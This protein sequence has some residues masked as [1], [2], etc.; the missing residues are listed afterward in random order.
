MISGT[1]KLMIKAK[2]NFEFSHTMERE[3]HLP[4]DFPKEK[5]RDFI[6]AQL[7]KDPLI[8]EGP[9]KSVDMHVIGEILSVDRSES[10]NENSRKSGGY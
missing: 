7:L 4:I 3:F 5:I 1:W 8:R 9:W 10:Y 6:M 2:V